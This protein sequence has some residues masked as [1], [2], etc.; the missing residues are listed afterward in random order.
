MR[1]R[2]RN[3][4]IARLGDL[5][6]ASRFPGRAVRDSLLSGGESR[7]R[8]PIRSIFVNGLPALSR[9]AGHSCRCRAFQRV[10]FFRRQADEVFSGDRKLAP[11]P[12]SGRC[13]AK[14]DPH[15]AFLLARIAE[16]ADITMPELSAEL[17]TV[18]GI[19]A[20]L[21]RWL[22]CKKPWRASKIVPTSKRRARNGTTTRQ[23]RMRLEPHRLVF[24]DE[25]GTKT[26]MTRLR[27]RCPKGPRLRCKVPFG[28]WMTQTFVASPPSSS[29]PR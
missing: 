15:R 23:P 24:L 13:H 14:L 28:H 21:S 8:R 26:K 18:T 22:I 3:T 4:S 2:P 7:C 12:S 10:G 1:S 25:T 29:T 5:T 20:S 19:P 9:V 17:A 6:E 27:G 11:K 16:K